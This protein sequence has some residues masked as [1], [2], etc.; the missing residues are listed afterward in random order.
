MNNRGPVPVSARD[1]QL[2]KTAWTHF[3]P[4]VATLQRIPPALV[5]PR[6]VACSPFTPALIRSLGMWR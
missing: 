6:R 4:F 3:F 1:Q 2:R 5:V